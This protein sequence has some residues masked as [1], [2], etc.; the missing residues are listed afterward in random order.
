MSRPTWSSP[1]QS[2]ALA[3]ETGHLPMLLLYRV[4][5]AAR[6]LSLS[7]SVTFELLRT[8]RL[9]SVH[10]GRTRLIPATALREYVSQLEQKVA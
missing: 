7:R 10:E 6:L 2:A 8:G 5:D 1:Q 9:R 3:A 4:E